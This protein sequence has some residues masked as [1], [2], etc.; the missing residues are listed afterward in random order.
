MLYRQPFSSS[1]SYIIAAIYI[2][3]LDITDKFYLWI[4]LGAVTLFYS[5][6]QDHFMAKEKNNSKALKLETEEEALAMVIRP[7][8]RNQTKSLFT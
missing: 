1:C 2:L 3:W 6:F 8:W 7:F 5:L 4:A